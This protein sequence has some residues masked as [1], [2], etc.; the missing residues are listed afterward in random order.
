MELKFIKGLSDK[1]IQDLNKL[2]IF[3][4]EDLV[5]LFPRSYLDMRKAVSLKDAI[6]NDFVLTRGTVISVPDFIPKRGNFSFFKVFCEQ[7]GE[8]FTITWFNQ[9]YIKSKLKVGETYLFYGRVR[10]RY[11]LSLTNPTFELLDNNVNLKGIV[12]VYKLKGGLT[13]RVLRNAIKDALTKVDIKSLIPYNLTKTFTLGDLKTAY[14]IVH[15]PENFEELSNASERIATEEYFLLISSFKLI[16]GDKKNARL[17]RYFVKGAEIFEWVKRFGFEFTDGQKKA[18]NEIYADLKSP[19]VMN[20]LLQGDVGSG[21]T[22][23]ALTS[24]FMA[25]KSNYQVCFLAPTE[26]LARQ[27]FEL[28]KRYLPEYNAVFLSGGISQKEKTLVKNQIRDGEAKIVCGTHAILEKDVKFK[29]LALCVCDEQQRF[30]VS[31][32]NSLVEKGNNPDVLIMSATPIPRTLSLVFYGDLDITT[33]YDKPVSRAEITTR[34]V[35]NNRYDDMLKFVENEIKN[36][37]Q[38]YFVCPKIFGDDEGSILSVTE[39][40]DEL[41]QKLPNI[42]TALLHGKMKDSEKTQIMTDFKE[43]KTDAI[44][45][46]TVIEVGIDVPNA[47]VMVIYGADRFGLSQLHQLRGRV[48]RSDLASYCFLLCDN[49]TEKATERLTTLKD[50]ADG[51]KIAESDYDARGGGDFMGTKQSG[52]FMTELGGLKYTTSAIFLAKKLSDE[53]I[54]FGV[55]SDEL[56]KIAFERYN[57]LKDVTLN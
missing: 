20:R 1:R 43:K 27:N 40:F 45:S 15:N 54:E 30:G 2:G 56:K 32:R 52:K 26:V 28:V 18:V 22:A 44:V 57:A 34:I 4:A 49:E 53:A 6:N 9:P 8:V 3:S 33:I 51:F 50:N 37:R 36:G 48:G 25:L 5:R 46:T 14:S 12:P 47:T 55:F 23:V 42:K 10:N 38:A 17:T 24:M 29:N 7:D 11:A 13:Q 35:P 19:N 39:I 21:K 31:Q 16:K 41:N